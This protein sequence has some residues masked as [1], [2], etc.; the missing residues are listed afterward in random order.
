MT[1]P[2]R[3]D[4]KR[5]AELAVI[6]AMH[7]HSCGTSTAPHRIAELVVTMQK[8]ARGAKRKAEWECCDH[9]YS[10]EW[11]ARAEGR[12]ANT[13]AKIN[14]ALLALYDGRDDAPTIELGGDPRG[15]C[16]RLHIPGQR[17]DGWG[18]GFAIY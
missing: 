13:Q 18:D 3:S 10:G 12:Q 4:P 1:D 9:S 7:A 5:A 17:G 16:A 2:F 11:G 15:P 6:L 14:A 8:A